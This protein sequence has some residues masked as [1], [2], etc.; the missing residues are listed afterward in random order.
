MSM[1]YI[2]TL[3][4]A[5]A[6]EGML[7]QML[8]AGMTG[9]RLNLSH[10]GLR[11]HPDWLEAFGRARVQ[12]GCPCG[13]ILDLQ[14]K[15]L[16]AGNTRPMELKDKEFIVLGEEL[17]VPRQLLSTLVPGDELS[18]DDGKLLL[19]VLSGARCTVVRGGTLPPRK[20]IALLGRKILLPPLTEEDFDNLQMAKDFGVTAVM[21]PFV[22]EPSDI[23]HL[24]TA[25]KSIGIGDATILAKIESIDGVKQIGLLAKQADVVVIAR[26][27]L[28]NAQPLWHV[29][30]FQKHIA[31]ACRRLDRPFWVATQL[32]ASLEQ[33]ALPTRA[34]MNDIFTSV[35][36]GAKGLVLTGETAVGRD[37]A[38]AIR[39]LRYAAEAADAYQK[40]AL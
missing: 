40:G 3:G 17:S 38:G 1:Q 13:L 27:D 8:E 4:P 2:G 14:G 12:T 15:E 20:S 28:G 36:D 34:E 18:L 16:R 32:L 7:S 19:Q 23:V 22:E 11:A 26:G 35:L 37:P 33:N 5:C 10:G 25:L 9:L 39:W 21:Q 29:P 31:A 24:R 6:D 30:A